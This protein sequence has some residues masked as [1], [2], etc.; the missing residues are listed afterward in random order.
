MKRKPPRV[1][2]GVAAATLLIAA[3]GCSKT[4]QPT[5][6][7]SNGGIVAGD[8]NAVCT[9]GKSEGAVRF[10]RG[11]DPE[12]DKRV[13]AFTA[14]YG[15]KFETADVGA[16]DVPQ[17]MLAE[18]QAGH[19]FTADIFDGR[20]DLLLPVLNDT[21]V[22]KVPVAQL[23][24]NPKLVSPVDGFG[25][26]QYRNATGIAYD[27]SKYTADQI[28]KTYE[29]LINPKWA[30]K[31][32]VDPRG[33]N[34]THLATSKAMGYDAAQA[35]FDR[36][37]ETDKPIP[38]QGSTAN[39]KAIIAGQEDIT[40]SGTVQDITALNAK[41]ATLGFQPLDYVQIVDQY[42]Y[43][44][45]GSPNANAA[46]CFLAW[47][48]GPEGNQVRID[49]EYKHNDD[50]PPGVTTANNLIPIGTKDDLAIGQAFSAYVAKQMAG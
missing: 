34:F 50:I 4:D 22:Q 26:R 14:K 45:K 32:G 19:Q 7:A 6:N 46:A 40:L 21:Y 9:A 17:K 8:L 30:G 31:I 29:E 37:Y 23:G 43:L 13:A 47:W 41:G 38:V 5:N 1:L 39:L 12:F 48:V 24:I 42:V 28:P 10:W 16:G 27:T 11:P 15:I 18:R 44:V 35:W 36:F 49:L 20:A 33:T 25:L 2:L 3:A